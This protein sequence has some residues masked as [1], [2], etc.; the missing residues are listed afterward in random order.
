MSTHDETAVL[1]IPLPCQ[2]VKSIQEWAARDAAR[3]LV[4]CWEDAI[5]NGVEPELLIKDV[6]EVCAILGR[7]ALKA[8][9]AMKVI[10]KEGGGDG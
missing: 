8:L 10:E 2:E 4:Y 3:V 7:W 9:I 6:D 5:E 1:K